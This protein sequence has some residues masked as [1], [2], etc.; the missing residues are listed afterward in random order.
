MWGTYEGI[1]DFWADV[2]A[3]IAAGTVNTTDRVFYATHRKRFARQIKTPDS[4]GPYVSHWLRATEST[5]KAK[6]QSGF[7]VDLR[8]DAR[9][10]Y[11]RLTSRGSAA[12]YGVGEEL[13]ESS[14]RVEG[15]KA[16]AAFEEAANPVIR[17]VRNDMKAHETVSH[18]RPDMPEYRLS[19]SPVKRKA[20]KQ[21]RVLKAAAAIIIVVAAAFRVH[22]AQVERI[23][24][25]LES[26]FATASKVF[27][28]P[29]THRP[30]VEIR[31][32]IVN[33][34][35]DNYLVRQ[36]PPIDKW[37]VVA[38]LPAGSLRK[39]VDIHLD[40]QQVPSVVYQ[41]DLLLRD[42]GVRNEGNYIYTIAMK[43]FAGD[44]VFPIDRL[45]QRPYAN[46]HVGTCP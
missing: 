23:Q 40:A 11:L 33:T 36:E 25:L 17:V 37:T 24:K 35:D 46:V 44:L 26:S 7:R 20:W 13:H 41:P 22:G 3:R 21:S 8:Q 27:C 28:D 34:E 12:Q 18:T 5:R 15:R 38:R 30:F 32:T 10:V 14:D 4:I 45:P 1:F 2:Q 19:V 42:Y 31:G 16:Q 29:N 39:G 6:S 9:R 43:T